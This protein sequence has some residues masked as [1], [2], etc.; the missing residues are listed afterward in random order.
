VKKKNEGGEHMQTKGEE[1]ATLIKK[2]NQ[3]FL[4]PKKI[5]NGAV[6]V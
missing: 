3:I 2:E 1:P 6:V 4:I 5:Q